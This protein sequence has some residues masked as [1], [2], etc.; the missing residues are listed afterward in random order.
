M[1]EEQQAAEPTM[2]NEIIIKFPFFLLGVATGMLVVW[3]AFQWV[4][5]ALF[6]ALTSGN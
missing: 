4:P 6:A 3:V 5:G 2:L 1:S